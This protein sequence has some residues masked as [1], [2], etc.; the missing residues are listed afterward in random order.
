MK[1][2]SEEEKIKIGKWVQKHE[3]TWKIHYI[4]CDI[5][6]S[7]GNFSTKKEAEMELKNYYPKTKEDLNV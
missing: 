2:Y 7:V 4:M 5:E 3:T 6:C 1:K